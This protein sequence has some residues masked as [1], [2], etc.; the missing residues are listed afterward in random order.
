MHE[1]ELA[2]EI[3]AEEVA[4]QAAFDAVLG[5]GRVE[6]RSIWH[7]APDDA[8]AVRLTHHQGTPGVE[9]A[10]VRPD[11]APEPNVVVELGGVGRGPARSRT[12]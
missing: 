6:R 1:F 11:G 12:R 5:V 2:L 9:A 10:H 8:S 7:A 4:D 3:P